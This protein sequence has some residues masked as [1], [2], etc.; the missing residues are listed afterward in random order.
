[1]LVVICVGPYYAHA[2]TV[3][4]YPS[5]SQQNAGR[6]PYVSGSIDIKT[7]IV[8]GSWSDTQYGVPTY[9]LP[10]AGHYQ[11]QF[12]PPQGF[13]Y[14][15]N[16]KCGG[17]IAADE[18]IVCE[19]DYEDGE[20]IAHSNVL[21]HMPKPEEKPTNNVVQTTMAE[22]VIPDIKLPQEVTIAASSIS[23]PVADTEAQQIAELQKQIIE[24]YKILIALLS[25]KLAVIGK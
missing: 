20:P 13:T 4:V 5:M 7:R 2:A 18:H 3:Q 6:H 8:Q 19:V 22:A 1:M 14:T 15:T 17:E 21:P 9:T 24:L 10:S 25:Q 16:G 12:Y 11:V 23:A